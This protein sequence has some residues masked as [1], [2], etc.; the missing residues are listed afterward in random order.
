MCFKKIS[1]ENP[2]E[3]FGIPAPWRV[4]FVEEDNAREHVRIQV[5]Y[6]RGSLFT[7]R[8]AGLSTSPFETLAVRFGRIFA[9]GVIVFS[10]RRWF[11]A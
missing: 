11:R 9:K 2:S 4:A 1:M 10:S 5:R 7:V 3:L 6:A 8:S